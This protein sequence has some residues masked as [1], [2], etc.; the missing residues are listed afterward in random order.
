VAVL[1]INTD[2][3]APH[4]LMLPAASVR[5]TLDA[6]SLLDA[7]VRLNGSTLTLGA[8]DELPPVAG[9]PASPGMMTFQ[10]AT[11][12]FL[13]IPEAGNNACR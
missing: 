4:S 13:A 3:K 11:I 10:Q 6:A 9:A 8:G 5:Y 2:S 12:I 7:S 1:V